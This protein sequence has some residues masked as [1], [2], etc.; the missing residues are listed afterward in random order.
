VSDEAVRAVRCELSSDFG[1]TE[2]TDANIDTLSYS[3]RVDWSDGTS[4]TKCV[5]WAECVAQMLE[6]NCEIIWPDDCSI[7]STR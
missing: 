6:L 2:T 1:V 4:S 7:G 5:T 3:L